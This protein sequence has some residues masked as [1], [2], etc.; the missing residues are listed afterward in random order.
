MTEAQ[1]LTKIR[2]LASQRAKHQTG[3]TQTDTALG[4]AVRAAFTDG[5][6]AP[7]IAEAARLSPERIYQLRDGRR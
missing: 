2:Y 5:L 7:Q 1:H 6:T 3:L 4:V